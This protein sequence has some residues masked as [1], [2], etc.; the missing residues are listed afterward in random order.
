MTGAQQHWE[1]RLQRWIR[2]FREGG[3]Y[4][5]A[6]FRSAYHEAGH[7]VGYV[8]G[9]RALNMKFEL[10]LIRYVSLTQHESGRWDGLIQPNYYAD[11]D[12]EIMALLAG[13]FAEVMY[14]G[15]H[16]VLYSARIYSGGAADF[17]KVD[18]L[19]AKLS[20]ATKRKRVLKPFIPRTIAF[21]EAH[22]HEVET[23]ARVLAKEKKLTGNPIAEIIDAAV[24][25]CAAIS[26]QVKE[27]AE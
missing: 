11:M 3:D 7:A 20:A 23:L 5:H 15:T 2:A 19:I 9:L 16:R 6:P 25:P 24:V 22:W 13:P 27:A 12:W 8:H 14:C 26:L 4:S 17:E 1:M 10:P 21:L 18:K